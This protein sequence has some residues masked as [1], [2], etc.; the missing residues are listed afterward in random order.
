MKFRGIAL[1]IVGVV[2]ATMMLINVPASG[3][4]F[5]EAS[6]SAFNRFIAKHGKSY[7][8]KEEY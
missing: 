6:D 3:S 5:L 7:A 2:A 4:N 8:T 1:A